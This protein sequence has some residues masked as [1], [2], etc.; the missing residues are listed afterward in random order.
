[1]AVDRYE[2]TLIAYEDETPVF[3]TVV[4]SGFPD[5]PTRIGVFKI[6]ARLQV[7]SMSGAT[8][9]PEAYNLQRVPW[10][11]YFDRD[12]SLHGTY[13]HDAFGYRQSRGC[14]NLSVSDA[15]WLYEWTADDAADNSVV[16]YSSAPFSSLSRLLRAQLTHLWRGSPAIPARGRC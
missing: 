11:M 1:M 10:V 16:V 4:S 6:W 14:V 7:D 5:S 2:Q 3:A 9:A 12:I 13:W 8:G 15:R